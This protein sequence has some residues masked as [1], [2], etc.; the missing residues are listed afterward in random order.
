MGDAAI[1]VGAYRAFASIC[2]ESRIRF[3]TPQFC[4][5]VL[6]GFPFSSFSLSQRTQKVLNT[7]TLVSTKVSIAYPCQLWLINEN[8][9][10]A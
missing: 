10:E 6:C 9:L 2:G 8:L 3:T 7:P 1:A 4:E 5:A